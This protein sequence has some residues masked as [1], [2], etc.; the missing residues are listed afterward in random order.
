MKTL[1]QFLTERPG[2]VKNFKSEVNRASPGNTSNAAADKGAEA[3]R[4]RQIKA[5]QPKKKPVMNRPAAS[6][7]NKPVG[8]RRAALQAAAKSE[9]DVKQRFPKKE[10]EEKKPKVSPSKP[11]DEKPKDLLILPPA[12]V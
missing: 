12:D 6:S 9:A 10:K 8:E 3:M 7:P 1:G 11:V 2:S 4:A 5:A